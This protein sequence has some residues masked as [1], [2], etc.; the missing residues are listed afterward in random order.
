ML[1]SKM[2]HQ[3]FKPSEAL[4]D[5]IK[6]FWHDKRDFEELPASFE[7]VPDGSLKSFFISEA[8]RHF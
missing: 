7:V 8:L 3:E 2:Q 5:A 1:S 6:C 4:R